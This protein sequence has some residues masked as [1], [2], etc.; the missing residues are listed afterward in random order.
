MS[1]T[2]LLLAYPAGALPEHLERSLREILGFQSAEIARLEQQPVARSVEAEE[3]ARTLTV[4][5]VV[6]VASPPGVILADVARERGVIET[7]ALQVAGLFGDPPAPSDLE[8]FSLPAS[9]LKLLPHC[10]LH[11]CKVKLTAAAIEE[12]QAID[13]SAADAPDR[14]HAIAR[15][16]MLDYVT[17][18]LEQGRA[19]LAVFADKSEPLSVADGLGKL[20]SRAAYLN[21]HLPELDRHLGGFPGNPVA[22]MEDVLFWTLRD[23]GLQPVVGLT[24]AVLYTPRERKP[25][26]AVALALQLFS[27]HYLQART[28]LA[29]LFEDDQRPGEAS[30]LVV[31]D[32]SLFDADIGALQRRLIRSG[33]T[34]DVLRRVDALSGRY[35]RR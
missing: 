11:S 18:Y 33:M 4:A 31:V 15:R 10:R 19:A 2:I 28:Q 26:A 23:Y 7:E 5:A 21:Q 9:D 35:P 24:H 3:G 32:R 14:A 16:R 29:A 22:G 20:L 17:R 1:L 25:L 13:W 8:A 34:K 30:W 27:T 6:R 12:F